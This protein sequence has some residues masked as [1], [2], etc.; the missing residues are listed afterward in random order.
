MP[1]Q[2]LHL[3]RSGVM[4]LRDGRATTLAVGVWCAA[5]GNQ[6]LSSLLSSLNQFLFAILQSRLSRSSRV[7]I[8]LPSSDCQC[9]VGDTFAHFLRRL[10]HLEVAHAHS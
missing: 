8:S 9:A 7:Q 1:W 10:V 4:M 3:A 5:K 2:A 6:R